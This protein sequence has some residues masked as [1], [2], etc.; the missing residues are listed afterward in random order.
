MTRAAFMRTSDRT[1][2]CLHNAA[3]AFLLRHDAEHL[4]T[5]R[6]MLIDRAIEFLQMTFEISNDS[7]EITIAHAIAEFESRHQREYIDLSTST[8]FA[9]FV[10]DPASGRTRVFTVA[11]L[12]R[13][14]HTPDLES[15]PLPSARKAFVA[16]S[17]AAI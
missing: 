1:D 6:R 13:L 9:L 8:S 4:S 7:A 16:G 10:R 12:M 11:Q 3:I 2:D 5:D 17:L 14:V 15:M